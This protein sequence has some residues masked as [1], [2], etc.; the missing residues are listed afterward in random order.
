[1]RGEGGGLVLLK[2][3]ARAR[4]DGDRILAVIRGSAVNS[5]GAEKGMTVPDVDAQA[6]VL[7]TAYR[8]AGVDPAH[9]GH[10]ELHGTG[11]PVGD[12]I[13]AAALGA[14][15]GSARGDGG[16]GGN[17][18][19]PLP[20]GSV[21]TNIGHLEGAAGI[22]GLI[23]TVLAL[24]HRELPPSLNFATPN[25]GIPLD[26]LRLRVVTEREP[27]EAPPGGALRTAGVSSFG[28]GGT[29]CHVVLSE[30][31][32]GASGSRASDG[33]APGA[34][35]R[36]VLQAVPWLVSGKSAAA[37]DAQV[38]RLDGFLAEQPH[39][40]PVDVG[41]SLATGRSV[42]EHRAMSIQGDE[43]V[44]GSVAGS[45]R[46][47]FVFPGQGSQWIGM[48]AE[49]LDSSPS[50]PRPSPNARPPSPSWSAGP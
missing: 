48:G 30:E 31:P 8:R 49:L 33:G 4:E 21:K 14:V 35:T 28:M 9:V 3:L 15:L 22:A 45:G 43:W 20:V 38:E 24:H 13:E 5:G 32:R 41:F 27:L 46:T 47:V 6:E 18:A 39:L 23:K 25:P 42:F 11:T 16:G 36:P 10:V 2:P 1:M 37:L 44:R 40:D 12:P 26:E 29:N 34:G 50:S 19:R 7:R 17:G